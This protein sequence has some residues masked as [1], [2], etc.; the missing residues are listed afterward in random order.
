MALFI[1]DLIDMFFLG[2]LGEAEL[3]AAIGYAGTIL[4]F[5]T[6]INIGAAIATGALT[7]QAIGRNDQEQ[8]KSVAVNSIAFAALFALLFSTVVWV[9]I[10]D[11]LSFLGASGRTLTLAITYLQILIP[12]MAFLAIGMCASSVLRATGDA[13]GAMY[14]TLCGGG[15]NLVLDPIFIFTFDWGIAGAAWA[16]VAARIAVF[17]VAIWGASIKHS[18]IGRFSIKS[19]LNDFVLVLKIATPAMLTNAATPIGNAYVVTTV[20]GFGDSAVAGMAIV[21]RLTPVAFGIIFALSGAVGPIVGQNY[22]AGNLDRVRKTIYDALI[23]SAIVVSLISVVLFFVQS[24]I[25]TT[26]GATA[27]A[28]EMVY[29][30]CTWVAVTFFF[31]GMV[32]I[33]NAAFNNLGRPLYSTINNFCKAVVTTVPCVYIG[34][35]WSEHTGV[36][37]GQAVSAFIVGIISLWFCFRLIDKLDKGDA[38]PPKTKHHGF[39]LRFPRWAMSNTR[40]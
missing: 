37:Y 36:L 2:L 27:Q 35:L 16:S 6:S 10:P 8:A 33:A 12:S 14:A 19:F 22:G 31:T 11:L 20:A 23:F 24:W 4:F 18:L 29:A 21:G 34:A 1:V 40:G 28:A 39:F 17:A 15:V 7:S 30:F 25:I 26:F 5:T 13:K 9:L 32:F 3:A 38:Q